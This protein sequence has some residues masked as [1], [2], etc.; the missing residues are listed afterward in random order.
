MIPIHDP[1]VFQ[2][3]AALEHE[4]NASEHTLRNYAQD[5]AQFANLILNK[6][7]TQSETPKMLRAGAADWLT[8]DVYAA[9]KFVVALQ[10]KLNLGRASVMRKVSALRSFY[11]YLIRE[12]KTRTNPFSGL[13]SPKRPHRLPKFFSVEQINALMSAPKIYW[14]DA[15]V[16]EYAKDER[17]AHF[18]EARDTALLEVIYSGGLRISEAVGLNIGDVDLFSDLAK[19]RGKGKKERLCALG[20]PALRALQH[21]LKVRND[22]TS[23]KKA[24]APVFINHTG[25]RLTQR[26]FQRLFK[27]YLCNAGLPPDFTPHKLRHSFAT[28]L[29]DNGADLRS[30]QEMLGHENLSTTQIYTHISTERMKESYR[31]AH[32]R[33]TDFPS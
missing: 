30:V 29:L 22:F 15:T 12:E 31:K 1:H 6:D 32:P 9:R 11:R 20:G 25:G 14:H 3:L 5:L 33:A 19:V 10:Q 2:F 27:T 17:H 26:S 8:V 28:H 18:A 23:E 16:N 21:Y 7:I 24:N 4:R 13:L